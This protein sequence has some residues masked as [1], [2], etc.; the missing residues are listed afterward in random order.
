MLYSVLAAVG[1]FALLAFAALRILPIFEP[2]YAGIDGPERPEW[3]SAS[4]AG[5]E[6]LRELNQSPRKKKNKN[7]RRQTGESDGVGSENSEERKLVWRPIQWAECGHTAD[8]IADTFQFGHTGKVYKHVLG[9]FVAG[10][11]K[12]KSEARRDVLQWLMR[13][14]PPS[15]FKTH[16]TTHTSFHEETR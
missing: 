1:G 14:P 7:Q 9:N 3:S 11:K 15:K 16:Y 4:R 2:R 6:S 13:L 5:L 8:L 12:K 10:Q